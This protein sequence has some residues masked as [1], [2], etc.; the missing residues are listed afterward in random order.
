MTIQ[1]ALRAVKRVQLFHSPLSQRL[2]K[3][4]SGLA[5]T[6][7]PQPQQ[8]TRR[9]NGRLSE[10]LAFL[11]SAAKKTLVTIDMTGMIPNGLGYWYGWLITNSC[12]WLTG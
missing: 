12:L 2:A 5:L 3:L 4:H 11:L 6:T 9:D 10:N 8:Y 1:F 7:T